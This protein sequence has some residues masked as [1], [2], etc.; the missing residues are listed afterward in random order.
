MSRCSGPT[1]STNP[2]DPVGTAA[3]LLAF[4]LDVNTGPETGT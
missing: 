3:L 1:H 4:T 2:E